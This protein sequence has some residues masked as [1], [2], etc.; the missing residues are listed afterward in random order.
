MSVALVL[1][2]SPSLRKLGHVHHNSQFTGPYLHAVSYF[3]KKK[4][5][6]QQKQAHP[7][8]KIES[9]THQNPIKLVISPDHPQNR[10]IIV[11]IELM[12]SY[13]P[14]PRNRHVEPEPS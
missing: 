11:L 12:G 1:T 5:N 3:S 13:R 4:N 9:R 6:A 7:S 8:W 14:S 10:H 2:L